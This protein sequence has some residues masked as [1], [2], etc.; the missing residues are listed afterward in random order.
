M[1]SSS[2]D[3][4]LAD[5]EMMAAAYPEEVEILDNHHDSLQH[6]QLRLSDKAHCV[7]VLPQGYPDVPLEVERYRSVEK[8]RMEAVVAAIRE[9]AQ[10]CKGME[11]GLFCC[12]VALEAWEAYEESSV[13]PLEEEDVP[14]PCPPPVVMSRN[15]T[16]F[17]W[18]SGEPLLDR[19]SAFQAHLCRITKE[20]DVRP[21]LAELLDGNSKLRRAS[22]NMVSGCRCAVV[23]PTV[24][25]VSDLTSRCSHRLSSTPTAS[26]NP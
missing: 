3:R 5:A 24:V 12:A 10:E 22:H 21:A 7:L 8:S 26:R 6:I 2:L 4:A 23:L 14:S 18:I 11:A 16:T 25:A 20:A 17:H 1:D 13:L 9:K 19:K 15:S